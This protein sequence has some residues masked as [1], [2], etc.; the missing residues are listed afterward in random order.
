M[1]ANGCEY[2]WNIPWK[3][4]WKTTQ[5]V[6]LGVVTLIALQNC[7]APKKYHYVYAPD[8]P[9]QGKTDNFSPAELEVEEALTR[10]AG[11]PLCGEYFGP[12]LDSALLVI[13]DFENLTFSVDIKEGTCQIERGTRAGFNPEY[14]IPLNRQNTLN[15]ATILEDGEISE[16]EAYRIHY[17]TFL[18]AVKSYFRN[19]KLYDPRVAGYLKLPN[20][21]HMKLLNPQG[22]A[23]Q[24]ATL[25]A[26]ATVVNVDGR[27]LV[28][29]GLVGDPEVRMEVTHVQAAEF[30]R[31]LRESNQPGLSGK[32]ARERLDAIKKFNEAVTVYRRDAR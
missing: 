22:Y 9:A 5:G 13:T 12:M 23:Y 16:E 32:E 14:I 27:W 24:G 8:L 10:A 4:P 3:N 18:P 31:M 29:P 17:V 19:E 20:F 7:A 11:G 30:T 1:K 26:S 28:F 21:M 2:P 6:V 15:L 25:E